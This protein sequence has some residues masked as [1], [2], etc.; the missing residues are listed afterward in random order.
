MPNQ[1]NVNQSRENLILPTISW[2]AI[3]AGTLISLSVFFLFTLLSSAIGIAIMDFENGISLTATSWST[4]IWLL[5][6]FSIAVATGSYIAA[7]VSGS[8]S[9]FSGIVSGLVVWSIIS[10]FTVGSIVNGVGFMAS[11]SAD[12][13]SAIVPNDFSVIEKLD[14]NLG[15]DNLSFQEIEKTIEKIEAPQVKQVVKTEFTLIKSTVS[16]VARNVAFNPDNLDSGVEKIKSQLLISK[17]RLRDLLDE[18]KIKEIVSQN[19]NM[20]EAEINKVATNWEEKIDELSNRLENAIPEIK[21]E[22]MQAQEDLTEGADSIKNDIATTLAILF[23]VLLVGLILS[24][25]VGR[26]GTKAARVHIV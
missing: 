19:S 4:G 14:V 3:I 9:S 5:L 8:I 6:S 26:A 2:G 15:M 22:M 17:N 24:A 12:A 20:S 13:V 25:F 18:N 23:A 10:I 7:R 11:K 21:G 16:N 1:L